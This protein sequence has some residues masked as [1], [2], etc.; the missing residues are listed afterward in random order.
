MNFAYFSVLRGWPFVGICYLTF[1]RKVF[2][3]LKMSFLFVG[4][5]LDVVI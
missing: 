5:P 3:A 1:E 4:K 2:N